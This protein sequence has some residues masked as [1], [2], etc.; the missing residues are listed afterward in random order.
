MR[1]CQWP[2]NKEYPSLFY[3]LQVRT[4]VYEH[5]PR[6]DLLLAWEAV[7][8]LLY[9]TRHSHLTFLS[10]RYGLFKQ[11]TPYLL[12]QITFQQGFTGDD[13][14]AA[15]LGT[16]QVVEKDGNSNCTSGPTSS[17]S[18]TCQAAGSGY[19]SPLSDNYLK[20]VL[21]TAGRPRNNVNELQ[22]YERRPLVL[23][24]LQPLVL[25]CE[26]AEGVDFLG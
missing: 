13:F 10:K 8:S 23:Q 18:K 5:I 26:H 3:A 19:C 4:I 21:F 9:P 17:N 14:G 15:S 25:A 1:E 6:A 11:F 16:V 7:Q 24:L 20:I 22:R 12:E 2:L